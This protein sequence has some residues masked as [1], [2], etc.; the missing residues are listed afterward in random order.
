MWSRIPV[1]E[2]Y[3]LET[4]G[5]VSAHEQLFACH[6]NVQMASRVVEAAKGFDAVFVE[7]VVDR[8][9]CAICLL[10]L[11]E[12]VQTD[13]GYHFCACCLSPNE[14]R[15][16]QSRPIGERFPCPLC[17][18]PLTRSKIF[19]SYSDGHRTKSNQIKVERD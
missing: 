6:D 17:R 16:S 1:R 15:G 14:G 2:R 7:P 10:V 3:R 5:R 11:R 12:P 19:P 4:T 13:C 8:L 9:R 18:T